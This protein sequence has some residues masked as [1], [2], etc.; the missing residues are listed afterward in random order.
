MATSQHTLPVSGT[1]GSGQAQIPTLPG[2]S[3]RNRIVED[4]L[5]GYPRLAALLSLHPSFYVFRNFSKLRIRLLLSKQDELVQLEDRL[6]KLDSDSIFTFFRGSLRH[7]RNGERTQLMAEIERVLIDYDSTL[8][9]A[10]K[11]LQRPAAR[12]RDT[13]NVQ[14]WMKSTGQIPRSEAAYLWQEDLVTIGETNRDPT[15]PIL[16]DLIEDTIIWLSKLAKSTPFHRAVSRDPHIHIFSSSMLGNFSKFIITL[17]LLLMLFIPVVISVSIRNTAARICVAM[18][19]CCIFI[20]ALA[21]VAKAKTSELF[22]AG[23]TYSA[24][25]VAFITGSN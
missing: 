8:N 7:D 17:L 9:R 16:Q 15:S 6:E 18:I 23:A 3:G 21:M 19:A 1:I 5:P 2:V 25:L 12:G 13:D 10:E 11:S 20:I 24:I 22:V 14:N 4:H